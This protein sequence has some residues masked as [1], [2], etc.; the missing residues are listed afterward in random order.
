METG[1]G[2]RFAGILWRVSAA[3]RHHGRVS[4]RRLR[5]MIFAVLSRL[6]IDVM[7]VAVM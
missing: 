3:G 1:T 6:G 7:V 2:L 5:G 4:N